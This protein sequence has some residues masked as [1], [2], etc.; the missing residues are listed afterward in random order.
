[1]YP[2]EFSDQDIIDH[3]DDLLYRFQNRN[4]GD[5]V[6]RV[7]MDLFRKLGKE[8]RLTAAIHLGLEYNMPTEKI[9]HALVCGMYFRA[10]NENGQL[11]PGDAR[12]ANMISNEGLNHVL[13]KI[14]GFNRAIH[15]EVFILSENYQIE[16]LTRFTL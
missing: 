6:F 15:K 8:D 4:L 5:P 16:I 13:E 14:C 9:L 1:M 7:G 12:F 3:I 10:K 2:G 11:F